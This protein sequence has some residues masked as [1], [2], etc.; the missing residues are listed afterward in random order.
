MKVALLTLVN[1]LITYGLLVTFSP[2]IAIGFGVAAGMLI[3]SMSVA[4]G[5]GERDGIDASK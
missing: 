4:P 3:G 1:V 5:D 2:S